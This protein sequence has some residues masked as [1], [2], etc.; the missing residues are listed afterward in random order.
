MVGDEVTVEL[1]NG[2]TSKYKVLEVERVSNNES[3]A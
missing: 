3:E 1:L 2:E